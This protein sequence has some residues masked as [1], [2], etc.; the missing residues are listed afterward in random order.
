[1]H[2]YIP[3]PRPRVHCTCPTHKHE[4][5]PLSPPRPNKV[6]GGYFYFYSRARECAMCECARSIDCACRFPRG[7]QVP[8]N[9][10]NEITDRGV[11]RWT[12]TVCVQSFPEFL[13]GEW[14]LFIY[15]YIAPHVRIRMYDNIYIY[16]CR[17]SLIVFLC[18]IIFS[19][20]FIR[21]NRFLKRP[22]VVRLSRVYCRRSTAHVHIIYTY[23]Q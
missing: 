4:L 5:N 18:D 11:G 1:L 20:S 19:V 2:R 15:I 22:N 16:N 6:R 8:R 12:K 9:E 13:S 17:R 23:L 3:D 21:L 7:N 14:Y 10:V